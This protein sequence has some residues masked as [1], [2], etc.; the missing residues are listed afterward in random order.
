M[1]H[2]EGDDGLAVVSQFEMP[3]SSGKTADKQVP[4]E[5][6]AKSQNRYPEPP[7]NIGLGGQILEFGLD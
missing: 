3:L 6:D 1:R 5:G 7:Q 2:V 4:Y